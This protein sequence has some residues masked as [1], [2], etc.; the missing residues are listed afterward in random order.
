[1]MKNK[2]VAMVFG[3]ISLVIVIAVIAISLQQRGDNSEKVSD[4]RIPIEEIG[5]TVS[6]YPVT[7]DDTKI[8]VMA[9]KGSDGEVRTTLNTCD[10]SVCYES[11][12]GYYEENENGVICVHC[13][14]QFKIDDIGEQE[15]GCYPI[16]IKK[17]QRIDDASHIVIATTELQKYTVIFDKW[18]KE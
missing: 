9:V 14:D 15:G 12:T 5:E 7:I 1:M 2:K 10:V 6:Y 18:I 13:G 17:T 4:L 3:S 8:E 11:G 16:P